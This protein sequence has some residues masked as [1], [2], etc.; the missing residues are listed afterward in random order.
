M[1]KYK[2]KDSQEIAF[3]RLSFFISSSWKEGAAMYDNDEVLMNVLDDDCFPIEED[4][5]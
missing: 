3:S 4:D 1:V 5:E 2:P